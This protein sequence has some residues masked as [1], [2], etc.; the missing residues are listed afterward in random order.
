VLKPNLYLYLGS[1]LVLDPKGELA[2]TTET[3]LRVGSPESEPR[4][5]P[6]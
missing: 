4:R 5:A 6:G 1:K 2:W 3:L